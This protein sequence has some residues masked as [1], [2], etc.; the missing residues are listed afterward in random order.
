VNKRRISWL[1]LSFVIALMTG[2]LFLAEVGIPFSWARAD[3]PTRTTP[4][5]ASLAPDQVCL[6]WSGDPATTQTVQWRTAPDVAEGAVEYRVKGRESTESIR[7][8]ADRSVIE[9]PL[10]V[11]D[12]VNH[13]FS[14]AMTGLA[15]ATT[16]AYRVGDPAAD[17]WSDWT[18]FTTAPADAGPFSF[19]YLG[20]AQMG[21]EEWSGL[22]RKARDHR[23]ETAF[24]TVAGDLVNRGNDREDWDGFF[25][26]AGGVFDHCPL[27]PAVGNHEYT[28]EMN[29]RLYLELLTLPENGPEGYFP[30]RIY[31][32][33]YRDALFVVLDA[34]L[35]PA[36]QRPWLEQQL[37]GTDCTWK[38]AV[39]HQPIYSSAPRR[40]NPKLR[41]EWG[42]LFDKYHVDM[43]FQGHDHAYLRTY[44]MRAKKPVAS[45]AKGTIY[46][47]SNSGAKHYDQEPRDYTAVGFTNVATYQIIDIETEGGHKLTYRAYDAE[48]M[49][50][51][52]V[53]IE[54]R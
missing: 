45:P 43:V 30:E 32:L 28:R 25:Q 1:F 15:P 40:D 19:V 17:R 8:K 18:E 12:P 9:D 26:A 36:K 50:R 27:V 2:S 35:P 4:F 29:P 54:K 49:L 13:R 44:P 47:V 41:K 23:P 16:Y 42:S 31:S 3:V 22:L 6:T 10:V 34:N 20:D 51:D 5:P 53:V 38:F 46:V 7:V 37:A 11:N 14:A 21:F 48:G 52:E 33:R 39:F 24:F